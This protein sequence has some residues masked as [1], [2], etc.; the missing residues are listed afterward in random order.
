MIVYGLGQCDLLLLNISAPNSSIS[1][2]QYNVLQSS[3]TMLT[4]NPAA[5]DVCMILVDLQV[6]QIFLSSFFHISRLFILLISNVYVTVIQH[7]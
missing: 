7:I 6:G 2:N 3:H 4:A 5:A 1:E